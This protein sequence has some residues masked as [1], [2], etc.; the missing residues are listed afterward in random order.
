MKPARLDL[1]GEVCPY[2]FVR[3]KL[4]LEDL[5]DGDELTLLFD[6]CPAFESVPRALRE[7]GH[8]VLRIEY[9]GPDDCRTCAVTAKKRATP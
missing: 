6:H 8:E 1:R 3:T 2:T 9:D 5:E 4:A 7:D